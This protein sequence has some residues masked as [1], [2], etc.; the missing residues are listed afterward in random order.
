MGHNALGAGQIVDQGAKCVDRALAS[1]E[2]A[3]TNSCSSTL[4]PFCSVRTW[5]LT[6]LG[7]HPPPT[8]GRLPAC[9]EALH[10]RLHPGNCLGVPNSARRHTYTHTHTLIVL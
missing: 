1:G 4:P 2:P 8:L 7:F 10:L 3:P 5:L 6:S 9:H